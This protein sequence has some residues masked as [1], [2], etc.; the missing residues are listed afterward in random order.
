[1]RAPAAPWA[2]LTQAAIAAQEAK[3]TT[4]KN[5]PAELIAEILYH[6]GPECLKSVRVA[7]KWFHD[8]AS[9]V[10]FH[11]IR[12]RPTAASARRLRLLA[13]STV[14]DHIQSLRFDIS[15]G[16]RKFFREYTIK[17]HGTVAD[18]RQA[19]GHGVLHFGAIDSVTGVHN[20]SS[21]RNVTI[22][23]PGGRQMSPRLLIPGTAPL[24]FQILHLI[25]QLPGSLRSL[26]LLAKA[27]H[28]I[29]LDCFD[30]PADERFYPIYGHFY[31]PL[32][33]AEIADLQCRACLPAFSGLR[34]LDIQLYYGTAEHE[35]TSFA[36]FHNALALGAQS[37]R[38]LSLT[39]LKRTFRSARNLCME[40][41][42]QDPNDVGPYTFDA[43]VGQI[44]FPRLVSLHLENVLYD[45]STLGRFLQDH[46][47]SLQKAHIAQWSCMPTILDATQARQL[48]Q[49]AGSALRVLCLESCGNPQRLVCGGQ[50]FEYESPDPSTATRNHMTW[51]WY[52]SIRASL[53]VE[54]L[55]DHQMSQPAVLHAISFLCHVR[56]YNGKRFLN[57]VGYDYNSGMHEDGSGHYELKDHEFPQHLTHITT[58]DVVSL[59]KRGQTTELLLQALC[60]HSDKACPHTLR[61]IQEG[62]LCGGTGLMF[63]LIINDV[64]GLYYWYSNDGISGPRPSIIKK[65]DHDVS[66]RSL[67]EAG[68]PVLESLTWTETAETDYLNDLVYASY[69]DPDADFS[70]LGS[71]SSLWSE[72]YDME[73]L[74]YL[75]VLARTYE[76]F[77]FPELYDVKRTFE[78]E[79][80]QLD[81]RKAQ[82]IASMR[83]EQEYQVAYEVWVQEQYAFAAEEAA[84]EKITEAHRVEK[85]AEQP[86]TRSKRRSKRHWD[87]IAQ[88]G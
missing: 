78:F 63:A 68:E 14:K 41:G 6:L 65:F 2:H 67:L 82:R 66:L 37:F 81:E 42:W 16:C 30:L 10:L 25:R 38:S 27:S 13:G 34:S 85:H 49:A 73:G 15:D 12:L 79:I 51:K 76:A 3:K 8:E 23:A 33:L 44:F 29:S 21:V 39:L 17:D 46:N 40:H 20:L 36:N 83:E 64:P 60:T 54:L 74:Y 24:I 57:T 70:D 22:E 53:L 5:L 58:L 19:D 48:S 61:D 56:A 75:G 77:Q 32:T 9:K 4:I 80:D 62:S 52:Y 11:T 7:N 50:R 84:K 43:L 35:A 1:M 31:P 69:Q 47:Y 88:R 72:R 87:R 55:V 26:N 71:P 45:C 18:Y 86:K 28:I 59:V